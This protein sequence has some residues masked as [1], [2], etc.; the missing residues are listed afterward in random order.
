VVA[1]IM[2][3]AT[4]RIALIRPDYPSRVIEEI[5]RSTVEAGRKRDW[6]FSQTYYRTLNG[7]DLERAVD[8]KD[9]AVL[10]LVPEALPV[11]IYRALQKP[12]LPIVIAQ[13]T[14]AD[15]P[16]SWVCSDAESEAQL[17]VEHLAEL[18][19]RRILCM[20][21]G[22]MTGPMEKSVEGWKKAMQKLGEENLDELLINC[23]IPTGE[24]TLFRGYEFLSRWISHPHPHFTALYCAT[25]EGGMAFLRVLREHGI[26]VP[27]KVS[28]TASAGL[29]HLG[30]FMNPP[31]TALEY[32]MKEYGD[33]VTAVLN[34]LLN[35]PKR[36]T[37]LQQILIRPHLVTRASSG[38]IVRDNRK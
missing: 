15:P 10:L 5:C 32:E 36:R 1:E 22:I 25:S 16:T 28:V 37:T 14:L 8:G 27:Q 33:S 3:P 20:V 7:L 34:N 4:H 30:A 31:L 38:P 13:E 17:A 23:N 11:H 35:H 2:D 21:P 6:L 19:H 12:R 9:G 26:D 24:D 18:G 29:S